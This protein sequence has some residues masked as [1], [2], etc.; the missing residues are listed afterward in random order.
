MRKRLLAVLLVLTMCVAL[1]GCTQTPAPTQPVTEAPTEAPTQAPTEAPTEPE[2]TEP[3]EAGSNPLLYK[4]TDEDGDVVWLFGS[5]HVGTPEFYPLPDYVMNA[6]TQSEALAVEMDIIA[7]E[8]NPFALTEAMTQM[9]YMDQTTI[10]DH[11]TEELYTKAVEILTQEGLYMSLYDMYEPVIWWNLIDNS[12]LAHT[13]LDANLGIDRY[14]IDQAYQSG[15]E[16]LEV[17]SARFQFDLLAG[18]SEELQIFLLEQAVASYEVLDEGVAELEAMAQLWASGDEAAFEAY[19]AQEDLEGL[20]EEE[21]ALYEE[22]SNALITSRNLSMTE[23]AEACLA[24][25]KEVFICVGATHIVGEGAMAQL[26]EQ[27]G[28]TVELITE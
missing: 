18:F 17:E 21:L 15:K 9:I 23:Y 19:L 22:Y 28:Y 27:A 26:L 1:F 5:I 14:L 3:P 16:L 11:I 24:E 6:F 7:A 4:V 2:T 25:G 20:T 13:E 10:S 8:K 12:M